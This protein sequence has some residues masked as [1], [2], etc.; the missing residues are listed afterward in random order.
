MPATFVR[1]VRCSKNFVR[2]ARFENVHHRRFSFRPGP[3]PKDPAYKELG[4]YNIT[5]F[6]DRVEVFSSPWLVGV[7]GWTV[8]EVKAVVEEVKKDTRN[9]DLHIQFDL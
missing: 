7:L 9:P 8:D 5:Q 3:W 1:T 2:D 6:K 4:Q